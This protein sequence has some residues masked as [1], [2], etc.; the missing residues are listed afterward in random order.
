[1]NNIISI[2][3]RKIYLLLF[4]IIFF[5]SV[6]IPQENN[7]YISVVKDFVRTALTE[8]EGYEWLREL[9]EIGPRLSGSENSYKAIEWAEKKMKAL[10]FDV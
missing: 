10:G 2:S 1:L 6:I 9:C 7:N 5:T 3:A 4:T 8:Q